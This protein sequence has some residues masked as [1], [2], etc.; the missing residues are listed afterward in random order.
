MIITKFIVQRAYVDKKLI[1]QA[2]HPELPKSGVMGNN[3]K[4]LIISLRNGFAGS[5]EKISNFIE[6]FAGE[7]FSAQSIKNCSHQAGKDL[8]PLYKNLESELRNSSVVGGD[9]SGWRVNGAKYW[10]L[11]YCTINIVFIAIENSRKREMISK[12]FGTFFEGV[13]VSDCLAVYRIFAK[14]F[15]K[16]WSHLL[17]ST[18]TLAEKNPEKDIV[19][20]HKSLTNFFNEIKNFLNEDPSLEQRLVRYAKCKI[21]WKNI[22]R[23]KWKSDEAKSII[24]N[25]LKAFEGH[26]L[27]AILIPKVWLTNNKT[28]RHIR[29]TIP[30]RKLLGGH[31]TEDGAKYFAITESLRQTWKLRGLSP[32]QEMVE[33]FRKINMIQAL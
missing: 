25:R 28:E 8:E 18:H 7:K 19:L 26:W 21:V 33:K 29:A 10:L 9:E 1:A 32:Y 20:L 2:V 14:F 23:Y 5:C 3:L 6:D 4:S 16:C 31:R 17:R 30:T 11:L 15:Q 13:F 22:L 12:Y 24:K 27:T